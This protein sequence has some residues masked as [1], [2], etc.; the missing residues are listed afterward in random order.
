MDMPTPVVPFRIRHGHVAAEK[1]FPPHSPGTGT[2]L[3]KIRATNT[4]NVLWAPPSPFPPPF[5]YRSSRSANVQVFLNSNCALNI[6]TPTLG[7]NMKQKCEGQIS[8][9]THKGRKFRFF[10]SKTR[11]TAKMDVFAVKPK[12]QEVLKMAP[13]LRVNGKAKTAVALFAIRD[14]F[15]VILLAMC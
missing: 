11:K 7:K 9:S 12:L 4:G 5:C 14:Q 2:A 3:L 6:R 1:C 10:D 15:T 13:I 8:E